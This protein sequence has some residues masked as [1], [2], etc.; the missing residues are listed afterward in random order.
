MTRKE[1]LNTE[2]FREAVRK[3]K[4]SVAVRCVETG[5]VFAS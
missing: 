4:Y 5:E 1:N 2:H 3:R